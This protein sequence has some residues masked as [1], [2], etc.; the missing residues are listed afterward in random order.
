M[1]EWVNECEKLRKKNQL[2]S[3]IH[4]DKHCTYL[5]CFLITDN[6]ND[7][8]CVCQ[9]GPPILFKWPKISRMMRA[10]FPEFLSIPF[11]FHVWGGGLALFWHTH[12]HAHIWIR[13]TI[14]KFI[15]LMISSVLLLLQQCNVR[16]RFLNL[17]DFMI[18]CLWQKFFC[19][20]PF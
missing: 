17:G 20:P 5:N 1:T 9:K 7:C 15:T 4:G 12:T 3:I 13:N 2:V 10:I 6:D 11:P 8:V 14:L 16:I 19:A 18:F